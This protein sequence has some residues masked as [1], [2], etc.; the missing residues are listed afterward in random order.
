M[1]ESWLESEPRT[2][3]ESLELAQSPV[4]VQAALTRVEEKADQTQTNSQI[5]GSSIA[6]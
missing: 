3:A 1:P 4:E 6:S 5:L 2:E